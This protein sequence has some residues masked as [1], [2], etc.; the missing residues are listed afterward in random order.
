MDRHDEANSRFSLIFRTRLIITLQGK[1]CFGVN[2]NKSG[3]LG[4]FETENNMQE[5][6]NIYKTFINNNNNSINSN[7]KDVASLRNRPAGK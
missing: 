2:L 1:W 3:I 5:N 4:M 7:N 6:I